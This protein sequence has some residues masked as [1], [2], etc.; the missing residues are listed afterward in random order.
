MAFP[1]SE[2][3]TLQLQDE[4]AVRQQVFGVAGHKQRRNLIST[5]A[6][7][8]NIRLDYI[9]VVSCVVEFSKNRFQSSRRSDTSFSS[10]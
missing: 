8:W 7:V 4:M 5:V 6:S 1:L 9:S 2:N 10:K 3:L